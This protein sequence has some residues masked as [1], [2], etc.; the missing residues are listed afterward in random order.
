MMQTDCSADFDH[1][2]KHFETVLDKR[3]PAA[4]ADPSPLHSAMR[5][6][7]ISGGKRIRPMLVYSS[8]QSQKLSTEHL[9]DIACAIELIHAYSLIHDD[10]PAMD[11]DDLRRGRATCHIEFDEATA[12]LA[13]D[14][15]QALAFQTLAEAIPDR[16]QTGVRLIE[17]LSQACGSSGMAGGQMLDLEATGK[18]FEIDKLEHV[19]LLKT[20]AL[21]RFSVTAPALAAG[22]NPKIIETLDQFGYCVGLGF[23]IRDDI[24]DVTGDISRIGKTT[25]ADAYRNKPT[26]PSLIGLDASQKRAEALRDEALS[27]LEKIEGN[28]Q[29]LA[30]LAEYMIS[31]NH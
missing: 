2:K 6:A 8:G 22:S 25:N 9:D 26:F 21:I 19:H 10:L 20:G 18:T 3:L 4:D 13:G 29:T 23:Q 17:R 28:T 31:R 12:I 30:W 14:A 24:L 11:D 1:W 27:C 7:S 15:L 5:Y 16:P